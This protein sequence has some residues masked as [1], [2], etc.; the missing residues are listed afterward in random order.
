[1]TAVR[2]IIESALRK[3]SA[4]GE[5]ETPT[6]KQLDDGLSALNDMIA[7]WSIEGGY[8]YTESEE[9]FNLVSGQSKYTIGLGGNFDT[10]KPLNI[11]SAYTSMN[12][13]DTPL[14]MYDQ[15][16]YAR[17]T[18]KDTTGTPQILYF[19]N[20]FPLSDIVLWPV[21]NSGETI[22]LYTAKPLVAFATIFD[23]VSL[24]LGYER[25]LKYN[26]SI[27]IAPEYERDVTQSVRKIANQSKANIFTSNKR[28][29]NNVMRVDSAL[30]GRS[31]YDIRRGY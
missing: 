2:S 27:E 12:G 26:L 23:D 16:Q 19:D 10:T 25:A 29:D 17:I 5:G 7:S 14:E 6:A 22:T 21:P 18:N 15:S 20:D 1:M 13:T 3:I 30:I 28:N 24:P 11:S 31:G 9:T 4:L 8:I